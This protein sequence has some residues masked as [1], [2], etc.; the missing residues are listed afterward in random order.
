[1]QNLRFF[2]WTQL[3]QYLLKAFEFAHTDNYTCWCCAKGLRLVS[4]FIDSLH[5]ALE[6]Y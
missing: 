3:R 1:L 2:G 5:T 4:R 6:F